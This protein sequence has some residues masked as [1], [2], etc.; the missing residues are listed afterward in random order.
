MCILSNENRVSYYLE[1]FYAV[2]LFQKQ[3]SRSVLK[4]RC[5]E[6]IQ[7]VYGR[8]PMP[9]CDFNKV[10]LRLTEITRQHECSPVNL[11]HI[12]RAPFLKNA[13]GTAASEVFYDDSFLY[14]R[15]C[16]D[17]KNWSNFLPFVSAFQWFFSIIELLGDQTS[18]RLCI[19]INSIFISIIYLRKLMGWF[20]Y[21][22]NIGPKGFKHF[23]T[24]HNYS[25]R[26]NFT[27][28]DKIICFFCFYDWNH[29]FYRSKTAVK[30]QCR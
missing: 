21:L 23:Q 9:K 12:F 16:N 7:Q 13:S 2:L 6:N 22:R 1:N 8:T 14:S 24:V 15:T 19:S 4:K 18:S 28:S 17:H 20:L 10:A 30:S 25:Y 5:S 11:L 29:S 27:E 26:W 3:P